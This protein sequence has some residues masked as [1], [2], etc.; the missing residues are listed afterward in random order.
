M[1][2]GVY[3]VGLVI[4][5]LMININFASAEYTEHDKIINNVELIQDNDKLYP[6]FMCYIWPI[7]ERSIDDLN[8]TN[9][10]II[11]N[12]EPI[13]NY[14]NKLKKENNKK[15][16]KL[17]EEI[18]NKVNLRKEKI[19][20]NA[21]KLKTDHGI[22]IK[23]EW[24]YLISGVAVRVNKHE[25]K[26]LKKQD[27]VK[28][29]YEDEIL[30]ISVNDSRV[31]LNADDMW[32]L[33]RNNHNITGSGIKVAVIDSGIDYTHSFF[34]SCDTAT[35]VAG[36]CDR[37]EY[38][39]DYYNGDNDPYDDQYHG[40][41]V[42]GIL[43]A[44]DPSGKYSGIAPNVTFLIY[45]A[46]SSTGDCPISDVIS[47]LESAAFY[48]ASIVSIS[49][50]AYSTVDTNSPIYI[51]LNNTYNEGILSVVA[52]GNSGSGYET[53]SVPGAYPM[54]L[55]VG[56]TSK[57]NSIAPYSSRGITYYNNGSVAGIK[58]DVV[59]PGTNIVSAMPKFL[60][61]SG[62]VT[63]L[64]GT[65]MSTPAISGVAALLVQ[66]HPEWSVDQLKSAIT[67]TA[68]PLV[69]YITAT[70][71]NG[72]VHTTR[73]NNVTNTITPNNYHYGENVA[74]INNSFSAVKTFVITNIKNYSITYNI[75]VAIT[76]YNYTY[77]L[78]ATEFN[79]TS[80]ES[81]SFVLNISSNNNVS[82]FEHI[83]F[84]LHIESNESNIISVVPMGIK[85]FINNE[86]CTGAPYYIYN[87]TTLNDISC[88]YPITSGS[89]VI[90]IKNSSLTLTCINTSLNGQWS[91]YGIS[92]HNIENVT[93]T[94]CN[95]SNFNTP[96][97]I[98]NSQNITVHNNTII[99]NYRFGLFGV[100]DDLYYSKSEDS[101]GVNNLKIT[102]NVFY[103][104]TS[105]LSILYDTGLIIRSSNNVSVHK[106][107]FSHSPSR[108]V[109]IYAPIWNFT[110]APRLLEDYINNNATIS[111]NYFYYTDF[112]VDIA[113]FKNAVA[114]NN[115][116]VNNYGVLLRES[117]YNIFGSNNTILSNDSYELPGFGYGI[118]IG[119]QSTMDWAPVSIN[120]IIKGVH[121]NVTFYGLVIHE[122]QNLTVQDSFI[123]CTDGDYK[124]IGLQSSLGNRT[125]TFINVT[126]NE[127]KLQYDTNALTE[128][129][130]TIS[131]WGVINITNHSNH[132]IPNATISFSDNNSGD[133][134][135]FAS[136]ITNS[137]GVCIK[138]VPQ[139]V[140]MMNKTNTTYDVKYIKI[141][142]E[143]NGYISNSTIIYNLSSNSEFNITIQSVAIPIIQSTNIIPSPIANLTQNLLGYCNASDANNITIRY[144]WNWY[145][146]DI[147]NISYSNGWCYQ[148]TANTSTTCGGES[149]GNYN[150]QDNYFYIN[151][152]KPL[153][154]VN[155]S[156]WMVKHGNTSSSSY[157]ISLNN[158]CFNQDILQLRIYSDTTST[159]PECYNGSGWQQ[160]G[161]LAD[162]TSNN[163][164]GGGCAA[165]SD[166]DD[167]DDA[168]WSTKDEWLGADWGDSCYGSN[169][170]E[171]MIFEEAIWWDINTDLFNE[172]LKVN[173]H[174]VSSSI[175]TRGDNW[176]LECRAHDGNN[177]S[178]WLNSST[179]AINT[180][181]IATANIEPSPNSS[182]NYALLG[183]CNASDY[184]NQN[185]SYYWNWYK[186]GMIYYNN[187]S[188]YDGASITT[189]NTLLYN[190]D[191]VND[192]D[193]TTYG[194]IFENGKKA[195]IYY[196][197]TVENINFTYH[198]KFFQANG[199]DGGDLIFRIFFYNYTNNN[200]D[201]ISTHNEQDIALENDTITV[202][203]D[204][205][206]NSKFRVNN[207][208]ASGSSGNWKYVRF[209]D[210]YVNY[211]R[212]YTQ[213]INNYTIGNRINVDNM[214]QAHTGL[215]DNWTL[216]CRAQDV[217]L[218]T[219]T[220]STD[221]FI[222]N[223]APTFTN[224]NVNNTDDT[225]NSGGLKAQ[226]GENIKFTTEGKDTDNETVT[227]KICSNNATNWA[228]CSIYC[229]QTTSILFNADTGTNISCIFNT[230]NITTS[231]TSYWV[232]FKDNT[233]QTNKS[234]SYNFYV[235]QLINYSNQN[236]TNLRGTTT[237]FNTDT[238]DFIRIDISDQEDNDNS[239][240][241]NISLTAPNG[242]FV[243]E[244]QT[245]AY[246]SG[247]TYEYDINTL[248]NAV[249]QWNISINTTD[250][251]GKEVIYDGNF[252]V[253]DV[254][255]TIVTQNIS[256]NSLLLDYQQW[257]ISF[258]VV[259]NNILSCGVYINDI[260]HNGSYNTSTE[261][262]NVSNIN[263][264]ANSQPVFIPFGNDSATE[265]NGTKEKGLKIV[266]HNLTKNN[267]KFSNTTLQWV[268][269]NYNITI[270]QSV[271]YTNIQWSTINDTTISYTNITFDDVNIEREFNFTDLITAGNY[272]YDPTTSGNYTVDYGYNVWKTINITYKNTT[273]LGI[274]PALNFKYTPVLYKTGHQNVTL[275]TGTSIV[276]I[277]GSEIIWNM[278]VQGGDNT[279]LYN[280][281]H[282]ASLIYS[283]NNSITSSDN[284][285]VRTYNWR[286]G[287]GKYVRFMFT[288]PT[289][290]INSSTHVY[291]NIPY[292]NL[293]NW[294]DKISSSD[295]Y[296]IR[297]DLG[298]IISHNYND[299]DVV[300]EVQTN[301]Q[302]QSGDLYY[303]YDL[304][305]QIPYITSS[306]A[307][308]SGGGGG[309]GSSKK[310]CNIGIMPGILSFTSVNELLK[311]E[312]TN[313]EDTTYN[314]MITVDTDLL[315]VKGLS[316]NILPSSTAELTIE[317]LILRD[318]P[319]QITLIDAN[320][321]DVIIPVNLGNVVITAPLTP[322][323]ISIDNIK[324]A[325]S[326]DLFSVPIKL[327][328]FIKD[329]ESF[330]MPFKFYIIPILLFAGLFWLSFKFKKL[331]FMLRIIIP[332]FGTMII[333]IVI[334][335]VAF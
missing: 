321:I 197:F 128:N 195:N 132:Q 218:G 116:F 200:W 122:V 9:V 124:C 108:G 330:D 32:A 203:D 144:E 269:R 240:K 333:T 173:I 323:N 152:T 56:A 196:N 75:S 53:I 133:W 244:N 154:A 93:I 43:G 117:T 36:N 290:P 34:G 307:P 31:I 254:I 206:S 245:M 185:V 29:V 12:E 57:D 46:C 261:L 91:G 272:T 242:T 17:D 246:I 314:P 276:F 322:T 319:T 35:F 138:A 89:S 224:F 41:H 217:E 153:Y 286:N 265:T 220:D 20:Q 135:I 78:N 279:T 247:N 297:D 178:S 289:F 183:Y 5:I 236:D 172:S 296:V 127:S 8:Y 300:S 90:E 280:V 136:C 72:L 294:S 97:Y 82:R 145:K 80:N 175:T 298:N 221:T 125:M 211:N 28:D 252:H 288:H 142:A 143:K 123:H 166:N 120:E 114:L 27:F 126:F 24:N 226:V 315:L 113:N 40:T 52:A 193:V 248:L 329:G 230:T 55:T 161:V 273:E 119:R 266:Y 30:K 213:G 299:N 44:N 258:R 25:L 251:E 184:N 316:T 102:D 14:Q 292:A 33:N 325:L 139:K 308:P 278:S 268:N 326:K 98:Y 148:E 66:A 77:T 42:A 150:L 249:G 274:L 160:I 159:R 165:V 63:S 157:N 96:I 263:L 79:L 216:R 54:V 103:N 194:Y 320:C 170:P 64:S 283:E 331:P 270:N 7:S 83:W 115:L 22:E 59:A 176:T 104:A 95:L 301:W 311:F 277:N 181:P 335:Y 38:G 223:Y 332:A 67:N 198:Y 257:N 264:I 19:K 15:S 255:P 3:L 94:G 47:G 303:I 233:E 262:C 243:F 169:P 163:F 171:S 87:T 141:S 204:Y 92:G 129:N 210:G 48:N 208:L 275:I 271:N 285:D 121:I 313:N 250:S 134:S 209:Y 186:N 61:Y 111:N 16:A 324:N 215:Y 62:H 189:I 214:S 137:I 49:L 238:L 149:S 51:A 302:L 13:L 190:R 241:S 109:M 229:E 235:N 21:D 318:E 99:D 182:H 2:K 156:L 11:Y 146:N 140:I 253:Y 228:N 282:N 151:Y 259:D 112:A 164:E 201:I 37:F 231:N 107:Q 309:G 65:S 131:W 192:K 237:H 168:D 86:G 155:S 227:M 26:E 232:L 71:G 219:W 207:Y 202:H 85:D 306:P 180:L 69:S 45:K 191:N 1:K 118:S 84:S 81:N 74:V 205:I 130:I 106:N 73:A 225:A 179:T 188:W 50:G 105:S 6:C 58:P 222:T 256:L 162:G 147:K 304:E 239:F 295:A 18:K 212:I 174:N 158:E 10:I 305:W 70:V 4:L 310:I 101:F 293:N 60:G 68:T 234:E 327:P 284:N 88:I 39:Y 187:I 312:I 167:M 317:S 260:K 110:G 291:D 100:L 328:G 267:D 281:T 287:A 199:T 76:D 334:G 23:E 177:Y